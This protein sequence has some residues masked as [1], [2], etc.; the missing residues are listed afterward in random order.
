MGDFFTYIL[1]FVEKIMAF[2]NDFDFAVIDWLK[3][4]F[5]NL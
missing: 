4:L 2:I 3:E 5:G 1:E